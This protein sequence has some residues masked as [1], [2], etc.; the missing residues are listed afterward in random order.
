MIMHIPNR[1]H[2]FTIALALLAGTLFPPSDAFAGNTPSATEVLKQLTKGNERFASEDNKFPRM[3]ESRREE[4][5]KKGQH[6]IATVLTCS[7]SRV[8]PE[9]IFDQGIGDLFVIRVAGNVCDVDEMG[10]IEYAV[11]HLHTPVVIVLGHRSCG[12]VTAVASGA[13]LHGNLKPLVDNIFPAVDAARQ[14]HP[15]LQGDEFIDKAI[16]ANVTQSIKDLLKGSEIVREHVKGGELKVVAA[17]YN[18]ESGKVEWLNVY[19]QTAPG[20]NGHAKPTEGLR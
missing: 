8:P 16:R 11:E 4:T 18:L 15:Q 5:F 6:P 9:L 2:I 20:E 12:A 3:G 13:E 19:S 14:S 1:I 10:S 7:D 17:M